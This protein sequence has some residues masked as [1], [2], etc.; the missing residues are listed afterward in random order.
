MR[1]TSVILHTDDTFEDVE[2]A[3]RQNH[4]PH[5]YVVRAM[6][7]IDAEEIIPR[8]YKF[9]T[10]TDTPMYEFTMK[11]RDI[12]MRVA[13]NPHHHVNEDVS[14]IRDELYRL[15]SRNRSGKL[16]LQF[17]SGATCVAAIS[18]RITKFEVPYFTRLPELQLTVHC[19]DPIFRS[20][21]PIRYDLADLPTSG[22]T[23]TL[24]DDTSTA[25]HGFS[26]KIE[27][28]SITSTFYLQQIGTFP[29]WHFF[30]DPPT[31]FQIG[32]ELHFSSEYGAHD[33]FWDKASGTD[34]HLMDMITPTSVW[35][36]I[37]PGRNDFTI[38]TQTNHQWLELEFYA[39]FWGL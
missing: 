28:T 25:P 11:P 26:F 30:V 23:L 5:R 29:D 38:S 31:D 1:L 2:L 9:G 13:L 27:Y 32:D 14:D 17:F 18:G 7:G 19:V 10:E 4:T 33:V 22:T 6:T 15:I 16:Q 3:L 39:A 21:H 37:F 8:F 20:I 34:V 36:Q 24:V 12:T 35:P